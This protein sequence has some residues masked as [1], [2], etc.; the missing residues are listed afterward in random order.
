MP[1]A[2]FPYPI[3]KGMIKHKHVVSSMFSENFNCFCETHGHANNY[4]IGEKDVFAPSFHVN[5]QHHVSTLPKKEN[6]FTHA[7]I[8]PQNLNVPL[9]HKEKYQSCY[10]KI[11]LSQIYF[12]ISAMNF[13]K[14]QCISCNRQHLVTYVVVTINFPLCQDREF[15][16]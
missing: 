16:D 9:E 3:F 15:H 6:A 1:L 4:Y 7:D 10:S 13:S 5:I 11:P 14:P 8:R 2:R 12:T